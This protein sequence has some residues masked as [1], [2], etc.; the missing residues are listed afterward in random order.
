MSVDATLTGRA[1]LRI[2][3]ATAATMRPAGR[4]GHSD[5]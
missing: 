3:H 2:D 5:L 1:K 4:V